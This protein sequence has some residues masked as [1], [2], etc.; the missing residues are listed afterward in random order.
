MI[1]KSLRLIDEALSADKILVSDAIVAIS[2]SVHKIATSEK[3]AD[4]TAIA[5]FFEA[6]ASLNKELLGYD[7]PDWNLDSPY[8]QCR[9]EI[10]RKIVDS[11]STSYK[12]LSTQYFVAVWGAQ[13]I[14][15]HLSE[16]MDINVFTSGSE[17]LMATEVNKLR[18]TNNIL[19]CE[20]GISSDLWLRFSIMEMVRVYF[21]I[22]SVMSE[23][24]KVLV[25]ILENLPV[26]VFDAV[27][28]HATFGESSIIQMQNSEPPFVGINTAPFGM[29]N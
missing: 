12:P 29:L 9:A 22:K 21:E 27:P 23:I 2:N 16:I 11:D 24:C 25:G 20:S 26:H 10:V 13:Q 6:A 17:E 4:A 1:G 18:Q 14:E 15:A 19:Y 3:L 5:Y 7:E 8:R 28:N